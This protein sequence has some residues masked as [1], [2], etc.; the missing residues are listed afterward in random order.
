TDPADTRGPAFVRL[1]AARLL[2]RLALDSWADGAPVDDTRARIRAI[3][4]TLEPAALQFTLADMLDA[5]AAIDD[6]PAVGERPVQPDPAGPP[7]ASEL[8]DRALAMWHISRLTQL[9]GNLGEAPWPDTLGLFSPAPTNDDVRALW[10]MQLHAVP[11]LLA[12]L[13]DRRPTRMLLQWNGLPWPVRVGDICYALLRRI[14][15]RLLMPAERMLPPVPCL[16]HDEH[17]ALAAAT[18][19]RELLG[20]VDDR[21]FFALRIADGDNPDRLTIIDWYIALDQ[22][23]A[24]DMIRHLL[25]SRVANE[26]EPDLVHR[27]ITGDMRDSVAWL[28]E[29]AEKARQPETHLLLARAL[30][31]QVQNPVGAASVWTDMEAGRFPA[32]AAGVGERLDLLRAIGIAFPDSYP[33]ADARVAALLA[34]TAGALDDWQRLAILRYLSEPRATVP[35]E[36]RLAMLQSLDDQRVVGAGMPPSDVPDVVS[37]VLAP[38]WRDYVAAALARSLGAERMFQWNAPLA[39]RDAAV[40]RILTL[41]R[42]VAPDVISD[43]DV[44]AR[45]TADTLPPVV[46]LSAADATPLLDAVLAAD[47]LDADATAAATA[48]CLRAGAPLWNELARQIVAAR[49]SNRDRLVVLARL[50]AG[51]VRRVRVRVHA[52]PG[53]AA[54]SLPLLD[55]VRTECATTLDALVG[56]PASPS[57]L[58]TVIGQLQ[59]KNPDGRAVVQRADVRLVRLPHGAGTLLEVD[60]T[61]GGRNAPYSLLR[62]AVA[63][64][65]ELK[66]RRSLQIGRGLPDADLLEML[67]SDIDSAL[68]A[69]FDGSASRLIEARLTVAPVANN[70]KR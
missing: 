44:A 11:A 70:A 15:G 55:T 22:A 67:L 21:R 62:A 20:K 50:L 36:F 14:S 53:T 27:L 64:D 43:A 61:A 26:I 30:F 6:A 19:W 46:P 29:Y 10:R 40:G 13:T 35:D 38:R 31:E 56:R 17:I 65:G 59:M 66:E 5:L 9:T 63:I 48:A 39:T 57:L 12:G 28:A 24:F 7:E 33:H 2:F 8:F 69:G 45:S 58:R 49:A 34:N 68:S 47:E 54:D 16:D 60:I 1:H 37:G 32:D 42:Q 25:D 51:V 41:L 23:E 4:Q 18:A 52:A 3:R